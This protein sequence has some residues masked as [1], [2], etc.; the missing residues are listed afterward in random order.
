MSAIANF[1]KRCE[2]AKAKPAQS[3]AANTPA[4]ANEALAL[5]AALLG[6]EQSEALAKGRAAVEQKARF[7]EATV[8]FDSAS[9]EDKT[10][11]S[12]VTTDEDGNIDTITEL[13]ET[14]DT[15]AIAADNASEAACTVTDA[16][17]QLESAASD[18][19]DTSSD[20]AYNADDIASATADLKEATEELKKPSAAPKSSPGAKK[21]KAK[22][23]SKK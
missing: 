14:A 1:K 13:Q 21:G 6:C 3:Q 11:T 2:A 19:S 23:S 16:T 9:G 8:T 15:V 7:I 10:I 22:K 12:E 5:L 18:L 4:P 17:E 20:L